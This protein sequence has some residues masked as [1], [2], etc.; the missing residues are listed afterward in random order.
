[1]SLI[2]RGVLWFGAYV[3]LVMLPLAI[4]PFGDSMPQ[5]RSWLLEFCMA[6]AFI[7]FT[8]MAFE[9]ALVGRL[10]TAAEPF[11]I[12]AL[13]QFH[14]QMGIAAFVFVLVHVVVIASSHFSLALFNPLSGDTA[15]QSGAVALWALV[16]LIVASLWRTRLRL[17]YEVWQRIHGLAAVTTVTASLIHVLAVNR[18]LSNAVLRFVLVAY[19]LLF[20]ALMFGYRVL[21]PLALWRRPWEV[22]GN[23]DEGGDTRTLTV[24]PIKRDGPTFDP[25]Q[26]VWLST[27]RHPFAIEQHPISIASS[28]EHAQTLELSIKALGDWSRDV[29]PNIEP[30]ARVWIDGNYG[31]FTPD[32]V[33]AQGFMLIAGGVG[34]TP[35]RSILLTMRDREDVRPVTLIYAANSPERMIYVDELKALERAINLKCVFVYEAP[36]PGWQGERGFVTVDVLRRHLPKQAQR[37]EY[38]VCGPTP[39]LNLVEHSLLQLGIPA[40]RICS[41]RF[42]MG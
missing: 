13:M 5:P 30:G 25:G 1:M 15:Q 19:V 40:G 26:F 10:Q 14:R 29:V 18:Y 24:R 9:F 22:I 31:A 11:G 34:I 42:Q 6:I 16:A 41:E 23:R 12:D 20:L 4:A 21:R 36:P 32:R 2:V 7:A 28:A 3:V 39:M 17:P 35:M 37:Y 27:R 38:F 33:P 8:V